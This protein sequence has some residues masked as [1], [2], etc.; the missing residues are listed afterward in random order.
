MKKITIKHFYSFELDTLLKAFK[1]EDILQQKFGYNRAKDI[2]INIEDTA[3]GF[4]VSSARQVPSDVPRAL[5]SVL[6]DWNQLKQMETWQGSNEEG[7]TGD[8]QVDIEDVPVNI[9]GTMKLTSSGILTTN[10][11]EMRVSCSIPLLGGQLERFVIANIEESLANEH[12]F[13]KNCLK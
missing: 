8:I 6:G 7:F 4:V 12:T 9:S 10:E 11:I 5:R 3:T 2:S 13:I 1:D